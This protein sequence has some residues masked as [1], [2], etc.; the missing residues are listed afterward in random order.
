[1]T[2]ETHVRERDGSRQSAIKVEQW[3]VRFL[4]AASNTVTGHGILRMSPPPSPVT[5]HTH[6][7]KLP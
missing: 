3:P 1:M 7:P 4:T 5:R 2:I 6:I